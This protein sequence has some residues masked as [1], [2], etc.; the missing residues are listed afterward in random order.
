MLLGRCAFVWKD[1]GVLACAE[2]EDWR[3]SAAFSGAS[4]VLHV[5]SVTVIADVA[6]GRGEMG[7]VQLAVDQTVPHVH[8]KATSHSLRHS[9]RALLECGGDSEGGVS[10][11]VALD[12]G[13]LTTM[14]GMAMSFASAAEQGWEYMQRREMASHRAVV[15]L[16]A[17][18]DWVRASYTLMVAE[19]T[20]A[21]SETLSGGGERLLVSCVVRGSA[22]KAVVRSLDATGSVTVG[23]VEILDS[24]QSLGDDY[25]YLLSGGG[26]GMGAVCTAKAMVWH[27]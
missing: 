18:A 6:A 27:R 1:I 10:G 17:Y 3:S 16:R 15:G 13:Q 11:D 24:V 9:T 20:F 19:T 14:V 12:W 5:P 21:M 2:G 4:C 8:V 22:C 26:G 23:S 25:R 7:V